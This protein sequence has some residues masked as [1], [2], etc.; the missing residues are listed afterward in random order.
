[1][2][3]RYQLLVVLLIA[4]ND[5]TLAISASIEKSTASLA[6]VDVTSP[7]TMGTGMI[8]EARSVVIVF[9]TE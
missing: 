9:D 4:E 5:T 2:S 1:M 3:D 8:D 6:S 7:E